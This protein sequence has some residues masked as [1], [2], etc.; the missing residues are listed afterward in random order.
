MTAAEINEPVRVC[1]V[2]GYFLAGWGYELVGCHSRR[3]QA[4]G[5]RHPF[6]GAHI[7]TEQE[8]I[9]AGRARAEEMGLDVAP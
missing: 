7:P 5:Y 2:K 3:E 8:A 9:A 4:W 6:T 1:P